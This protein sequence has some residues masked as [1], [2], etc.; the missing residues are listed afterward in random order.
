MKTVD[1]VSKIRASQRTMARQLGNLKMHR[2]PSIGTF[3]QCHV[4]VEL[5]AQGVMNISQIAEALNLEPS[6]ISRLLVPLAERGLC[7]IQ[8]H[9]QDNRHKLIALTPQG[10]L[11]VR[12]INDEMNEQVTRA[13]EVMSVEEQQTVLQ[14]VSIYGETLKKTALHVNF[15]FR[16]IL[17]KD[18]PQLID[19][20]KTIYAEFDAQYL[21]SYI[22]ENEPYSL[23][24]LYHQ[25]PRSNYF[26]LEY[27]AKIV[28][29]IGYIPLEQ[30]S[31]ICILKDMYLAS[32]LRRL[33]LGASMLQKALKKAKADRFT[34]CYVATHQ[35]MEAANALFKKFGFKPTENPLGTENNNDIGWY[36]KEL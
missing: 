3:S 33:R 1:L 22:T 21:R 24:D 18:I 29:G 26:V 13:V 34:H 11:S 12:Q 19:L 2:F 25:D 17:K 15:Q 28:G 32:Y 27:K 9:P 20:I 14:G 30:A 16:K 6:T 35:Q 31:T 4:L 5:H 10:I 36:L 23:Y 7:Q 8:P